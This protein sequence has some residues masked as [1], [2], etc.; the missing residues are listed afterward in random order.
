M[1][2]LARPDAVVSL[3]ALDLRAEPSHRAELG[4]QLLL[5]ETVRVLSRTERDGWLRVRATGDG[6]SGWVRTWGLVRAGVA[7]VAR[8]R[9]KARGC[10]AVPMAGTSARPEG[11]VA[12]APLFLGA[13][14][15]AG[16]ARR[17]RRPVELPDGRRGW[18]DAGAVRPEGAAVPALLE[19]V[20]SLLGAPYLWGGRTVAGIDCSAFV[21]LVLAEQGVPLPRD[22]CDQFAACVGLA[23]G[24]RPVEGDLAFFARPGERA[25]HVGIALGGAWFAHSR[26]SVRIASLDSDNELWDKELSAQFLGWRRPGARRSLTKRK[27]RKAI[28]R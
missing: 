18:V 9:A 21:Q 17:G 23:A 15:I 20:T 13:R 8:W 4:S 12:V 27:P 11:G 10:I 7:R 14:V 25:S 3:P 24:D 22:A 19:R 26:G 16:P 1:T 5:G 28:Q 6:Y 2:P